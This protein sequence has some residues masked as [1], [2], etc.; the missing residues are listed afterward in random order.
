MVLKG[1]LVENE[2]HE[3]SSRGQYRSGAGGAVSR[4]LQNIGTIGGK[5]QAGL[6]Y[7]FTTKAVKP[8]YGV[9]I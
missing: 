6:G 8:F 1:V 7:L 3:K 4:I 2:W 5:K 9:D